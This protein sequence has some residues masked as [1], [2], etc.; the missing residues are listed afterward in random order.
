VPNIRLEDLNAVVPHAIVL[1][2]VERDER[3]FVAV[4]R[5][6]ARQKHLLALGPPDMAWMRRARKEV[7]ALQAD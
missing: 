4:G 5:E 1:A 3:D 2:V 7:V 6:A